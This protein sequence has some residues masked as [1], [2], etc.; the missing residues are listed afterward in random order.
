MQPAPGVGVGRAAARLTLAGACFAADLLTKAWATR[1]LAGGDVRWLLRPWLSLQLIHNSGVTL[2]LGA[3]HPAIWLA[4][5]SVAVP[6]LA[7]WLL[8]ARDGAVALALILGGTAGN[9]ASRIATGSVTDFVHL[10]FWPGV[11]NFADVFLRVGAVVLLFALW[12]ASR[13]PRLTDPL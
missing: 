13:R 11:F 9:L 7:V 8:R 6:L 2:G 12:R 1:A 4:V 10:W 3:G 5:G